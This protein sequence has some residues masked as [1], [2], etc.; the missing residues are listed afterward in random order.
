MKKSRVLML[1]SAIAMLSS[2]LTACGISSFASENVKEDT[3]KLENINQLTA[4]L[5]STDLRVKFGDENKLH[6]R[7]Y[8]SLVPEI[9]QKNG[10]LDIESPQNSGIHMHNDSKDNYIEITL[11]K[12]QLDTIDIDAS[13]GD[14]LFDSIDMGGKIKTSSGDIDLMN[15]ENGKDINIEV[16]SGDLDFRNCNFTTVN[17]ISSSGDT[18][19]EKVNADKFTLESTSG[20]TKIKDSDIC[21]MEIKSTSG[22]IEMNL[23]GKQNDCNFELS[24]TSGSI[25]VGGGSYK[26][27]CTINNNADKTIKC[28]AT[29]GEIEINFN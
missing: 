26:D 8:E 2:C 24:V 25:T 13:S 19:F 4:N 22:D 6:Y 1:I 5:S 3:V 7:V 14:I 20:E 27:N 16:S 10:R 15:I 28:N 9:N 21:D 18:H 23:N 12:N 29:S 17:K 11:N